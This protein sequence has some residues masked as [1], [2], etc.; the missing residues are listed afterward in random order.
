MN[1][2][3]IQRN[4]NY[5]IVSNVA[6]QSK[7]LSWKA[8]GLLVYL[9]TLPKDWD[10]RLSDLENRS[11]DGRDSTRGAIEE[12]MKARYISRVE[13]VEKGKFMGFDY[14]VSEEPNQPASEKPQ[15]FIRNGLSATENPTV[16]ST[17]PQST[18]QE[19]KDPQTPKGGT[20]DLFQAEP[21]TTRQHFPHDQPPYLLARRLYDEHLKHDPKYLAGKD[22]EQTLQ[23]WADD[24]EKLIRIDQRLPGDIRAVI[25]FAQR[26][27]FWRGNILSGAK[28][29]EKFPQLIIKIHEPQRARKE[30]DDERADRLVRE[31]NEIEAQRRQA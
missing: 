1:K 9:L 11:T 30:T 5:T 12:L 18:Q 16:I 26:D 17:H 14:T 23:R 13:C 3:T 28:L 2:L 25:E 24:I 15:R 10:V 6:L 8:K 22:L 7:E 29:R 21:K 27:S 20:F 31:S 4:E 19:K